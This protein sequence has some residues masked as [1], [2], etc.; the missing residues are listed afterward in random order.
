MRRVSL[1]VGKSKLVV[2]PRHAAETRPAPDR[3]SPGHGQ[4]NTRPFLAHA[5]QPCECTVAGPASDQEVAPSGDA[6]IK[7]SER[8]PRDWHAIGRAQL[9]RG[10]RRSQKTGG[11]MEVQGR[12]GVLT[13]WLRVSAA[14]KAPC[15]RWLR[16]RQSRKADDQVPGPRGFRRAGLGWQLVLS[17]ASALHARHRP[18]QHRDRK[19]LLS[20]AGVRVRQC[21]PRGCPC[22]CRHERSS[23]RDWACR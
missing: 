6:M 14:G 11:F 19:H 5:L 18:G 12:P 21:Q 9:Q 23:R 20:G 17:F 10:L 7:R 22:E 2:T 3:D 1:G 4:G 16:L 8:G 13:M 15:G